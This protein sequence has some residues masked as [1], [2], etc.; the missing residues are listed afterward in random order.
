MANRAA[1]EA[2][3]SVTGQQEF[4]ATMEKMMGSVKSLGVEVDAVSKQMALAG[5]RMDKA[6]GASQV[7][8]MKA[9]NNELS[10]MKGH[11]RQITGMLGGAG[12]LS[13]FGL[14]AG[15]KNAAAVATNSM[16]WQTEAAVPA[17]QVAA[18]QALAGRQSGLGI[19]QID[20]GAIIRMVESAYSGKITANNPLM[21]GY[22]TNSSNLSAI[23]GGKVTAL[24]AATLLIPLL[25]SDKTLKGDTTKAAS[26]INA[27]VGSGNMQTQDALS[28]LRTPTV[29]ALSG[30]G[31]SMSDLSPFFAFGAD[32]RSGQQAAPYARQ[33]IPSFFNLAKGGASKAGR[34]DLAA[35]LPGENMVSDL[36]A[37]NGAVNTIRSLGDALLKK[38]G[39]LTAPGA[40]N[41][42]MA[43]FG[44]VR[45]A[46][47]PLSIYGNMGLFNQ[48]VN[49]FTNL[50]DPSFYTNASRMAQLNPAQQAAVVKA[51]FSNLLTQV[52]ESALPALMHLLPLLTEMFKVM[53]DPNVL[54]LV[55]V[56]IGLKGLSMVNGVAGGL[57]GSAG[58]TVAAAR[59]AKDAG[60]I[61]KGVSAWNTARKGAGVATTVAGASEVAG[62]GILVPAEITAG[63][64]IGGIWGINQL[65]QH[66][67]AND[68]DAIKA[69]RLRAKAMGVENP[70]GLGGPG[71]SGKFYGI[72]GPPPG[73]GTTVNFLPGALIQAPGQSPSEFAKMV[74]DEIAKKQARQ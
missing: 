22:F 6:F 14:Y 23:S 58:T 15:V 53:G 41:D 3:L 17:S 2:M 56:M 71:S 49:Q 10:T 44:G 61:R 8:G 33:L 55:E 74:S 70:Y 19:N 16:Q 64:A 37:P 38:Y 21:Q 26:I 50:S 45:G 11:I 7:A 13:A 65:D 5:A 66:L 40:V 18:L 42:I 72:A 12:L 67:M 4:A 27:L 32:T 57:L 35:L 28:I 36:Q 31:I 62:A 51:G 39:S 52:G 34:A 20:A 63:I 29:G 47:N 73:S 30:L 59:A 54:R 46:A 9:T 25:Q 69:G 60:G 68:S 48:K 1:L 24:D 43:I